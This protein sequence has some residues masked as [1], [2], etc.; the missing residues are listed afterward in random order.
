MSIITNL[1][2]QAV[3]GALGGNAAGRILKN[4][5]LGPVGNS[6]S[7]AI[8]GGTRRPGSAGP[9]SGID[10]RNSNCKRRRLRY[11]RRTQPSGGWRRHRRDRYRGCRTDQ[12]RGDGA[13]ASLPK[14]KGLLSTSS[15]RSGLA[16]ALICAGSRCRSA[17]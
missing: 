7:G 6:I 5:N 15:V 11:C 9:D 10:R 8:G 2:V 16:K 1:I 14:N 4:I 13:E 12:E 17:R 3:A